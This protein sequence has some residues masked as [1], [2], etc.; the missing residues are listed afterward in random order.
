MRKCLICLM[1]LCLVLPACLFACAEETVTT[2]VYVAQVGEDYVIADID[3][4]GRVKI[5]C[6]AKGQGFEVF[7]TLKLEYRKTD[8]V[9]E[10]GSFTSI[11]GNP[12]SYGQELTKAVSIRKSKPTLGE[13]L[14]G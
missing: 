2:Y 6:D 7:D 4:E 11:A 3:G 5:M 1:C 10:E 9:V 13:P 14:Y 8:L 12:D